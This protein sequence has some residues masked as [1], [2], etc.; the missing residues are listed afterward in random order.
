M[1]K[2]VIRVFGGVVGDTLRA[3]AEDNSIQIEH[4]KTP[5]SP[6]AVAH[7]RVS[8][9]SRRARVMARSARRQYRRSRGR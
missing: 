4:S 6:Y 8:V 7:I 2:A 3:W 5:H 9:R 1:S